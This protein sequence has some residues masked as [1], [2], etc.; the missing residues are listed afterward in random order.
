[1]RAGTITPA[2]EQ[3]RRTNDSWGQ[4]IPGVN[5]KGP[6]R[7]RPCTTDNP[8]PEELR[9]LLE[10]ARTIAVVGLSDK[11]DRD[12]NRI[13]RYLQEQGY[14]VI[15]VNPM[16]SEVLGEKAYPSLSEIPAEVRIDIVDVFRRSEEV[17][18][19]VDEAIRRGVGALWL[20]LGVVHEAAAALARA[21]GLPVAQ[22]L[23]IMVTHRSLG[24]PST[25]RAVK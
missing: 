14:R 15:P 11:P 18:P 13:A 2:A 22:D 20:Q 8:S 5:G 25:A 16:L 17:P 6:L 12:S 24:L 1:V 4:A 9:R 7:F 21:A 10:G 23:C 19:I 3:L